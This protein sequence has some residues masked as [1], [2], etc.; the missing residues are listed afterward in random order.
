MPHPDLL[1]DGCPDGLEPPT[2][3]GSWVFAAR[4]IRR[5][6]TDHAARRSTAA[7]SAVVFSLAFSI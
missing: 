4:V 1:R 2:S 7:A 3:G 5:R 6:I